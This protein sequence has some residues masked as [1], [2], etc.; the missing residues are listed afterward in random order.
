ML[1]A[2]LEK[3][4]EDGLPK[5]FYSDVDFEVVANDFTRLSN[6]R[7]LIDESLG[8]HRLKNIEPSGEGDFE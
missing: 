3:G 1:K 7:L 8:Q 4:L 2:E 6:I 5:I